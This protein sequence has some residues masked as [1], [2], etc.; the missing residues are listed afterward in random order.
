MYLAWVVHI[1]ACKKNMYKRILLAHS[2]ERD[3]QETTL[4]SN[5]DTA[6][7]ILISLNLAA[8]SARRRGVKFDVKYV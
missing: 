7:L 8:T 3:S 5:L 4:L 1:L 6:A 2:R